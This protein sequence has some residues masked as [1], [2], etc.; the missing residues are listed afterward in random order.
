MID[1][2]DRAILYALAEEHGFS[3][4]GLSERLPYDFGPRH[5]WAQWATSRILLLEKAG[6]VHRADTLKPI[7]WLRTA[8]G[9]KALGTSP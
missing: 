3:M 8:A 9:T 7:L 2:T 1:S 6:L 5:H 4:A